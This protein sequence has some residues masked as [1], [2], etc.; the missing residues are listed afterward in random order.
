MNRGVVKS[1]FIKYSGLAFMT[2]N[3]AA[4]AT[5]II[6]AEIIKWL[7]LF[8][9]VRDRTKLINAAEKIKNDIKSILLSR[10]FS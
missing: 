10:F 8:L 6:P 1:R 5:G 3:N 2:K 9:P 7:E 4:A